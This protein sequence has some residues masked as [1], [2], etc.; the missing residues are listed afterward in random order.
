MKRKNTAVNHATW[1]L[2]GYQRLLVAASLFLFSLT[3]SAQRTVTG[4][5]TDESGMELIGATVL[6]EG[7]DIGTATDIDGSYSIEVP[8]DDA[9]LL[10]SYVGFGTMSETVGTRSVIDVELGSDGELLSEVV[11]VGYGT[12]RREAVTG[13]VASIQGEELTNVS[14]TNVTQSLQGRLP[15]VD[16]SSTSSRPGASAQI[17]IRGTRSLTASNDPLIVLDGIP[18]AGS[19]TDINPN[20]IK[21]VDVLKDA[22]ATAIYGSRGANGVVLITTRTGFEGQRPRLSYNAF[23]GVNTLFSKIPLM[24]GDDFAQLRDDAGIYQADG[25]DEVRGTNTDWQDLFYRDG[26]FMNHSL[27]LA[28]GT[29]NG[30]YSFSAGY[31]TDQAIIPEQGFRRYSL[32]GSLD[33]RIGSVLRVGFTTNNTYTHSYGND[34]SPGNVLFLSPLASPYDSTGAPR[35]TI[36]TALDEPFV[37]TRDVIDRLGERRIN[38]NKGIGSYNTL[39]GELTIPGIDGLSYRLNLGLNVRNNTNGNFTGEGV[40]ATNPTTPSG[41][42]IGNSLLTSYVLENLLNYNRTFGEVH[43]VSVLGLFSVQE[44]RFNSSSLGARDIPNEAFQYFNLGQAAGEITVNPN[45]QDYYVTGLV[46]YMGRI[47]YDYNNRYLFSATLRTDGSSRLAEGNKWH[48]YPALSAGWNIGQEAFMQELGWL[49]RLKLRVGWGQTSNQAISPYSTLGSLD[50]RP[51]N[52][53]S[54]FSTGYYVNTLP[55]ADLGWEYS[56]TTNVGADFSVL[57]NRLSGTLEYYVTN[58]EDILL[59]INLPSTAGVGSYTANIG[60]TKNEGFE[61]SL[62]GLIIDNPEG[63][64]WEAGFNVYRNVNTLT[65][66]ASGQ[67]RDEGN[68][69]FVGYPINVIYDYK[70]IGLWQ[71]GDPYL[72]ILEPGGNVGQIKVEY[73]GE[74]G[75][76]GEP[77]RAI[78]PDDRQILDISPDF[79]GGFNTRFTFRG[80]DLTAVGVFTS[81]GTVISTLYGSGGYLNLLSGRQTNVDVDYYTPENTGARYPAPNG[82]RSGDNPEYGSTLSYFDGGY[83][84]FRTITL[85]YDLKRSVFTSDAFS[86]FRIYTSVQ[87][88]FVLFS[89]YNDMTGMDPETNARGDEFQ[90]VA[91][92]N[93]RLLTIGANNPATRVFLLGLN[94]TF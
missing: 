58:T 60:T 86:Q 28:G 25:Q 55:N 87:N 66:L 44:D 7:T 49:N 46:S 23:A 34:L 51:Y 21:S 14:A 76:N 59:G 13:S 85:G 77:V 53:G 52:F 91:S 22:S 50:T 69:W 40:F 38:E 70:R 17:R 61:F 63:L 79:Q 26:L 68:S 19:L 48:T 71:E 3:L 64:S 16:I 9:V 80:I 30:S 27:G 81:G 67:E 43:N 72:D 45:N 6:V 8:G 89:P 93:R 47:M 32:R 2:H 92:Y 54:E 73:T 18:F 31:N 57:S 94:V 74:Y 83:L 35:R 78:G 42:G 33:Q 5:V 10:F 84:K 20:D 15:G 36:R 56:V 88:P 29:E 82:V 24:N 1:C 90:A 4:Q 41:A 37:V 12:Q 62:N 75:E 65:S 39:F 11:V